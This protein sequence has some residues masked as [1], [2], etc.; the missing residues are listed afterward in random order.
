M[1][2]RC[3]GSWPQGFFFRIPPPDGGSSQEKRWSV[4]GGYQLP[5]RDLL[6]KKRQK[7]SELVSWCFQGKFEVKKPQ[8]PSK[9]PPWPILHHF[10]KK[11]SARSGPPGF[12]RLAPNI[13]Q[14]TSGGPQPGWQRLVGKVWRG[15]SGAGSH[16]SQENPCL[17]ASKGEDTKHPR[18]V[19]NGRAATRDVRRADLSQKACTVKTR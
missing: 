15:P 1:G 19:A 7:N 13:L 6:L 10:Q 5:K 3:P 8:T 2:R 11:F 18:V 9:T 16:P 4:E 17:A 14:Q 12:A